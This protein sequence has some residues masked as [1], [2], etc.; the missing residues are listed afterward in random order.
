MWNRGRNCHRHRHGSCSRH[1]AQWHSGGHGDRGQ[2]RLGSGRTIAAGNHQTRFGFC[3]N[4]SGLCC[5]RH[6]NGNGH[7]LHRSI[8]H[9]RSRHFRRGGSVR[10]GRK[11]VVRFDSHLRGGVNA[12][13]TEMIGRSDR[14]RGGFEKRSQRR[15][16]T[17][18]LCGRWCAG[19][20]QP[21]FSPRLWR[22]FRAS[23]LVSEM[24]ILHKKRT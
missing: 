13:M 2:G 5:C 12:G 3:H 16:W 8:G 11:F 10:R 24:V 6:S 19:C 21:W 23:S 1:E 7:G 15:R 14:L 9:R 18:R 4:R 17:F 20:E 22:N